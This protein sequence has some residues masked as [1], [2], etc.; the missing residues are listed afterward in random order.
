MKELINILL[1]ST[2][3]V[4]DSNTDST[5]LQIGF[6]IL[7]TIILKGIQIICFKI[8]KKS[9]SVLINKCDKNIIKRRIIFIFVKTRQTTLNGYKNA[10]Q[11][12][13]KL[14]S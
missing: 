14:V 11:S 12:H 1:Q 13:F 10:V 7:S 6:H 4:E 5:S 9:C 8:Y 2:E 3:S